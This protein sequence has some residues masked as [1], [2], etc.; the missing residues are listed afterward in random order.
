M[1]GWATAAAVASAAIGA[2]GA[3]SSAKAA[4]NMAS[5]EAELAERQARRDKQIGAMQASQSREESKRTEGTQR[6]LLNE[7]GG[8]AGTG[9]ALLVQEELAEEGEFN[10][11]LIEN[12]AAALASSSQ[13]QAV[14]AQARGR[15]AARAGMFRAGSAL[16]SGASSVAKI[17][18]PKPPPKAGI[19]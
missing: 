18:T 9:S 8:D 15:N 2:A 14:L 1:S 12:N 5:T 7:R 6:A 3:M 16:L 13:A 10:A 4:K 11:R 19:E 17:N